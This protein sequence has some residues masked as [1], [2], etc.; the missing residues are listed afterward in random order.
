MQ[1][2][3]FVGDRRVE[4]REFP[5]PEPG[6]NDVVLAIKASGLCGSDLHR[7]RAPI[8]S[9]EESTRLCIVGHE[10]AGQVVAVGPGVAP[11]TASV[12]DRVMVHHYSGCGRCRQ[13]RSGW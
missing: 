8:V 9:A 4:L 7:Y 6:P 2:L 13:C 1:G 10:P 11:E 5:D 12:G 3:V